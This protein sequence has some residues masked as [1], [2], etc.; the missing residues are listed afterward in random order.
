M[1]IYHCQEIDF[2]SVMKNYYKDYI[3]LMHHVIVL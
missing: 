2:M 3:T 1:I